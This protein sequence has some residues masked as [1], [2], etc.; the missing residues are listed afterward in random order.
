M[1]VAERAVDRAGAHL[2]H[3]EAPHRLDDAGRAAQEARIAAALDDGIDPGVLVEPVADEDL[4]PLHQ[5]DLARADLQVVRILS[6]SR[7]HLDLAQVAD[8]RPGDRPQVGQRGQDAQRFLR[9]RGRGERDGQEDSGG[10]QADQ[11]GVPRR[12]HQK[13]SVG[14]AP[15]MKLPCRKISSATRSTE[16]VPSVR[17]YCTRKRR[18]SEGLNCR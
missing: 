11:R 4:G 9:R 8:E 17:L 13:R 14:W 18:N 1:H 3:A 5:H 6:R 16:P 7:R 15:R 12:A 10:E 2:E